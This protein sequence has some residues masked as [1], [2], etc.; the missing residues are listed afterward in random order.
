MADGGLGVVHLLEVGGAG[1]LLP[2]L[3]QLGKDL[4]RFLLSLPH[5]ALGL[6]LALGPGVL[7][8]LFHLLPEDTCLAGVLLTLLPQAVGLG[9]GL[10]QPLPLLLQ[11]GQHVLKPEGLAVHLGLGVGDNAL[12]QSQPP[13]DGE[14][15]GLA[16]D[17]H[18]QTVGGPQR[19]H[20]E[21][22]AGVLHSRRG[23]GEGFQ[24]RVVGGGGDQR[25][26]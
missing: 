16:G 15:V 19:L 11:L 5:D 7:L 4:L 20:V 13:G 18:Q 21:F 26:L 23:H 17:A 6:G 9:L 1:L 12:V 24:L 14:G 2:Q 10:F 22:A 8:G 25:T 3:L